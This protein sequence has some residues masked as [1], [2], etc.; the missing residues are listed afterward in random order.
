MRT[1]LTVTFDATGLNRGDYTGEFVVR[2]DD[3]DEATVHV[4]VMIRVLG[5]APRVV[6]EPIRVVAAALPGGRKWKSLEIRNRGASLLRWSAPPESLI[7]SWIS[8]MP[9]L[10]VVLPGRATT[11]LVGFD[12]GSLV[13]GE[14]GLA[15]QFKTNDPAARLV[16]T[17]YVFHVGSI[18][19]AAFDLDPIDRKRGGRWIT[20][21]VELPQG[22]DPTKVVLSTVKLL[23]KI[24]CVNRDLQIGDFNRNQ[25][26]DLKF[27]FERAAVLANL[28]EGKWV[29]ISISGEIEDQTYFLG[30][31]TV[32]VTHAHGDG[33]E[34]DSLSI[35]AAFALLQNAPNPFNP[36]TTIRFDLPVP[37]NATVRIFGVDGRLA[38]EY[39]LGPLPAGRHGL[40]WDGRDAQGRAAPSGVYFCRIEVE[41]ES[42]FVASRRM[43]LIK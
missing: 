2:S 43:L 4:P 12:A 37:G 32:R 22:F 40:L 34:P 42:R 16:R 6:I 31:Q 1:Q 29:E 13:R 5:G 36:V 41:G 17:D 19:V 26:P 33:E 11:V 8:F 14:Y 30:N 15:G 39:P 3:P 35:P 28:P 25:I 23:G 20:A 10:G 21:R 7:P 24:P 9:P 38:R 27:R 18:P